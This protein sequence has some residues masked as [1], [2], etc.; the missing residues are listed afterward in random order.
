MRREE[1]EKRRGA[2]FFGGVLVLTVANLLVK[3]FGFLY[4]VPLNALLG[5]EMANVNAAYSVYALLYMLS[6]A[7][8]PVAVSVLVSRAR[9]EG[10]PATLGRILRVSLVSLSLLGAVGTVGL[11]LL[12]DP[13]AT[14][15]SGGDSYLCLLAIAPALFFICLSSVMRGYFQGF[16][17]MTPTAVS[18]VIEA[19]AKTL[20]GLLLVGL[21]L[22]A[23]GSVRLASA[24][25]VLAIT[26]GIA[27]G[28]LYLGLIH[29][30]Y[31][32]KGLLSVFGEETA[33]PPLRSVA[34]DLVVIA[35][36]IALSSGVLSLASLIDSQ[37]MRPL[38]EDY[39]G[40]PALAKAVFSDYSTGAVTLF[41]MPTVLVYPIASAIVPYITAARTRGELAEAGHYTSSALRIAALISLPAALG[42][43]VLSAPILDLVFV[44]DADMAAHAAAPLS[45][46]ALSIFP[47]G[48]LAVTNAVL[49]SFGRQSCPI[50]SMCAGV[51]VKITV[52][53]LL[54]PTLGP[55]AAP[56]GTLCFYLFALLFNMYF[57]FRYAAPI[58]GLARDLVPHLLSA[59]ASAFSAY[60]VFRL[61]LPLGGAAALLLAIA[62]AGVIY[63][64]L[65]L[66]LGGV[67]EE[68]ILLLPRGEGLCRFLVRNRLV[69][70]RGRVCNKAEKALQTNRKQDLL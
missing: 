57:L 14:A 39:F 65:I 48:L 43:S 32:K 56:L 33:P 49:Q 36:P 19:V 11:L 41:N 18:G 51:F 9:A 52:L 69:R 21:V 58:P 12:A 70:R 27:L 47:L 15:N 8:I 66:L 61:L 34:K 25:S 7:G 68:D 44:G 24:Y 16:G 3:V 42:M 29:T 20:L 53:L 46:L 10:R 17:L 6:T 13:I 50:L 5:D 26:V 23:T 22:S 40:D 60:G 59:G 28:A 67:D 37:M 4:K 62:A 38:L 64:A 63:V 35:V 31:Q 1:A 30:H 55:L 54:T 45:V 2:T